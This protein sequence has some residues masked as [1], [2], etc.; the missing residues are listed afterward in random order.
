MIETMRFLTPKEREHLIGSAE[1]RHYEAGAVIL[2]E[3][4]EPDAVCII[5]SGKARVEKEYFGASVSINRMGPGETFGEMSFLDDTVASASVVAEGQMVIDA[6]P[7]RA[8]DVLLDEDPLLASHVYR[9]L[10]AILAA[11]LRHR[12]DDLVIPSFSTG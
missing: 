4:A 10:A 1:E 12:T 7:R 9:S 8:L 11:R 2:A 5:R 3:G 6:I